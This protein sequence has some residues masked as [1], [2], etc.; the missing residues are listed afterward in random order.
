MHTWL[1]A[2]DFSETS[3]LAFRRATAQLSALG[4]GTIVVLNVQPPTPDGVAIDLGGMTSAVIA[5]ARDLTDEAVRALGEHTAALGAP[6]NIGLVQRVALGKPAD[7]IVEV[8][9]EVEADQIVLGSHGRRGLERVLLGSVAE[10]VIRH[11]D[12]PVLV[13]KG[14]AR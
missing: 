11:A 10:Q 1:V 6:A 4:G 5:S 9:R 2:F 12:R 13:V 3:R 8:A 7:V 14:A